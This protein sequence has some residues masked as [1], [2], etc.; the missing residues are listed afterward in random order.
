MIQLLPGMAYV[1]DTPNNEEGN[2]CIKKENIGKNITPLNKEDLV[3]LEIFI[4][5]KIM[6]VIAS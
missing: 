1:K 6:H 2:P 5:Y 4:I 3:A